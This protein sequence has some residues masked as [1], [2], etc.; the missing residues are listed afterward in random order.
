MLVD[1]VNRCSVVGEQEMDGDDW[2]PLLGSFGRETDGDLTLEPDD[3][4]GFHWL[5]W[6]GSGLCSSSLSLQTTA[7]VLIGSLLRHP[8]KTLRLAK[9]SLERV[10]DPSHT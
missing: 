9:K 1:P 5:H 4:M 8:Q 7:T 6:E 10:G 2:I 3:S